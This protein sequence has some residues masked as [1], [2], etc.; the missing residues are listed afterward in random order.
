MFKKMISSIAAVSLLIISAAAVGPINFD[1]PQTNEVPIMFNNENYNYSP[2][3]AKELNFY[4]DIN[5]SLNSINYNIKEAFYNVESN[6]KSIKFLTLPHASK[7]TLYFGGSPL[8]A[9]RLINFNDL[10]KL[11]F[12]AAKDFKGVIPVIYCFNDGIADTRPSTIR[13]IVDHMVNTPKKV[14]NTSIAQERMRIKTNSGKTEPE[15]K[16][17]YPRGGAEDQYVIIQAPD[18]QMDNAVA[19]RSTT[20]GTERAKSSMQGR[21]SVNSDNIM[22]NAN[23]D[24]IMYNDMA[25]NRNYA[26]YGMNRNLTG[27]RTHIL[28][29]TERNSR[30]FPSE[31]NIIYKNPM[32]TTTEIQKSNRTRNNAGTENAVP[33]EFSKRFNLTT[34]DIK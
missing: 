11:A 10:D 18:L 20:I 9:D 27:G 30:T 5:K 16:I 2:V 21:M 28:T 22:Y 29:E 26:M 34:E 3:V 25:S 19:P 31:A 1:V 33:L 15:I 24:I 6:T 17:E 23:Q 13:I 12:Y 7:G 32:A 8:Q 4:C 14:D